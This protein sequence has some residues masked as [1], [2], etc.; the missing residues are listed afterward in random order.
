MLAGA[1]LDLDLGEIRQLGVVEDLR[2]ALPGG[3]DHDCPLD[4]LAPLLER[5]IGLCMRV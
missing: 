4:R 1:Y 5:Q 2:G 3:L